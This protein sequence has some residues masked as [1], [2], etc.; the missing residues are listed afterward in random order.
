MPSHIILYVLFLFLLGFFGFFFPLV[1][2]GF[3][4]LGFFSTKNF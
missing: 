3:V 2:F 4:W 1:D